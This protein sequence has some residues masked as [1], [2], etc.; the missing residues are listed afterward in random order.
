MTRSNPRLGFHSVR[1]RAF[2]LPTVLAVAGL[3][4]LAGCETSHQGSGTGGESGKPMSVEQRATAVPM[5]ADEFGKLGYRVE[6]RAFPT[7]LPGGRLE[8]VDILGDALG[9]MDSEGVFS[10]IESTSGQQRW[11]DQVAGSLTRFFGSVRDDKHIVVLSESEAY[12]YDSQTGALKNKQRLSKVASTRPVRA[13]EILAYGTANGNVVGLNTLNGFAVWGS[14]VTGAVDVDPV[15]FPNGTDVAF[16]SQG[17]D[18][19]VLDGITG[20][21]LGRAR[22]FAGPGAA[23]ASN[24]TLVF[25]ASLDHS[26]Y[27]FTRNSCQQV[28]RHRTGN[29]LRHPP[30]HVDGVVYCDLGDSGGLSALNASTGK[31]IWNNQDVGGQVVAIRRNKVLAYDGAK[32]YTLD[33]AKGTVIDTVPLTNIE[34]FRSSKIKDDT[35]Y[36]VSPLGVVTKLS[37]K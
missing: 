37:P 9:A 18:V 24:D 8:S 20:R 26:L 35:L 1:A 22:M 11:S 15:G 29:P 4:A 19:L 6:W 21:G 3:V 25:V 12:Y 17:G 2:G 28:W 36:A 14:G 5:Q 31:V 30:V 13:G 34:F 16:A 10:V 23:I 32:M 7:M 27:A 33:P